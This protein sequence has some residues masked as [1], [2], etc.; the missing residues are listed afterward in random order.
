MSDTGRRAHWDATYSTRSTNSVSWY[1]SSAT[2]SLQ[3]ID[4]AGVDSTDP[5]VDIGGGA[6]VLV[7]D[8]LDCGFKAISVLDIAQSAL[9]ATQRRLGDRAAQVNW[10]VQ[11][12][13]RWRPEQPFALWHDRAAFH[14]MADETERDSYRKALSHGVQTGGHVIFGTFALDG[15][16]RCSGLPV[17]RYDVE[18]LASELGVAFSLIRSV[19][20]RHHTPGG[21]MQPFTWGLFRRL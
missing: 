19:E 13:T 5:L 16:D 20:E 15:P 7:D 8:L 3:L 6:S 12:V 21:A 2:V 10:I 9:A 11:D 18:S 4:V 14:F 17:C 1:Q